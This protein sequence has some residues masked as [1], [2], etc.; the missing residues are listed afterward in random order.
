[1]T[2]DFGP[3]PT[4]AGRISGMLSARA[5]LAA[6]NAAERQAMIVFLS[7]R[8]TFMGG[9]LYWNNRRIWMLWSRLEKPIFA[10]VTPLS[11]KKSLGVGHRRLAMFKFRTSTMGL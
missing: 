11:F 5:K 8:V 9:G 6:I 2:S 10:Q 7:L 1:L 3:L 4:N